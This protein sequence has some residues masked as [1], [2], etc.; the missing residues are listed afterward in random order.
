MQIDIEDVVMRAVQKALSA[1]QTQMMDKWMV[2]LERG[3]Q[4]RWCLL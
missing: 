3:G 4:V 2:F 1:A